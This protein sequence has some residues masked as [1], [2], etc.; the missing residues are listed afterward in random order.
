VFIITDEGDGSDPGAP[1]G[2]VPALAVGPTVRP[3]SRTSGRLTHYSL[4]RTI[5][6]AFGLPRLGASA[7]A[8]PVRGIWR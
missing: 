3:G 6:D 4:L 1:G 8:V 7:R 5:E 2:L